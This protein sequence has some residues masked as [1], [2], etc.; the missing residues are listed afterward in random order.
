MLKLLEACARS[1]LQEIQTPE[2]QRLLLNPLFHA[3]VVKAVTRGDYE[4]VVRDFIVKRCAPGMTAYD[5]GAN[6]GIFSFLFASAVTRQ[7]LV[8]A[9]EPEPIN[10]QCLSRSIALNQCTNII[11]DTRAVGRDHGQERFDRRGGA[12][13]GRLVG[14]NAAYDQTE[15]IVLTETVSIDYLIREEGY[16]IPDIIKIDVEGNEGLVLEGM[17]ETLAR[18]APVILCEL[19]THLGDSGQAVVAALT[20]HGYRLT[21]ARGGLPVTDQGGRLPNTHILAVKN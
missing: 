9:F 7:G 8:Y 17:T 6:I 2:G 13:S 12:F 15:N 18:H 16:K 10:Y 5:I 21:D 20:G 19:H 4:P 1:D 11:L 3:N 14:N